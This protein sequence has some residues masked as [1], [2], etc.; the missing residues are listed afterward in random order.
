MILPA[1]QMSLTI[2]QTH[3]LGEIADF[4]KE[5]EL[6]KLIVSVC[7]PQESSSKKQTERC[8][9]LVK[10]QLVKYGVA[11]NRITLGTESQDSGSKDYK[12]EFNL[13]VEEE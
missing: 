10:E 5:R 13:N 12:V 3:R 4:M 11:A 8:Y 6:M 9:N 1:D 2:E 7:P